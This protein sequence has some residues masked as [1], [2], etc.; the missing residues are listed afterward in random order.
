MT[1]AAWALQKAIYDA[2]GADATVKTLIGDPPRVYDGPPKAPVFPF[3]L[4]ADARQTPISGAETLAEHDLRLTV[5]S[6]YDGRREV[7]DVVTAILSVLDDA[8]LAL[9][10]FRLISLRAVF[11]DVIH[12]AEADAHHGVIR[13]RAV[14]EA[15]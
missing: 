1:A 2:L 13:L 9:D 3:V 5:H 8:P 7:K 14:T 10:G 12:R 6:R 4:F 11:I 15:L